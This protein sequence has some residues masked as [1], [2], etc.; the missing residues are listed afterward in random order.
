MFLYYKLML[1]SIIVIIVVIVILTIVVVIIAIP[2]TNATQNNIVRVS[3]SKSDYSTITSA[4]K[5]IKNA[6]KTNPF[7]ILVGPGEYT[8]PAAVILKDFVSIRGS[9]KLL[10]T[11][12]GSVSST[13]KNTS[14]LLYTTSAITCSISDLTIVNEVSANEIYSSVL[15]IHGGEINSF[16]IQNCALEILT[17]GDTEIITPEVYGVYV[18]DSRIGISDTNIRINIHTEFPS[19]IVVGILGDATSFLKLQNIEIT[20]IGG[21]Q[22]RGLGCKCNMFASTIT[23]INNVRT[24]L[25][26][27]GIFVE[28]MNESMLISDCMINV[29]SDIDPIPA[30]DLLVGIEVAGAGGQYTIDRSTVTV[31]D[32]TLAQFAIRAK[33]TTE[34]K[35]S[36]ST[37]NG[38]IHIDNVNVVAS[39]VSGWFNGIV[40]PV[41][42]PAIICNSIFTNNREELS[43]T[44]AP[45]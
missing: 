31:A 29:V 9:G 10:T 20:C 40:T 19:A 32:S 17:K 1:P 45:P 26:L 33:D 38:N 42:S 44:C 39:M 14:G 27:F 30:Q 25:T 7:I 18:S 11:I 36:Y 4:N 13:D 28:D 41:G 15:S 8:E 2:T 43:G 24:N 21:V 34:L 5:S 35:I 12:R 22:V 3:T 16:N 37:I 23:V 6:S